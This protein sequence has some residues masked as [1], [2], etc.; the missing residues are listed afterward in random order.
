MQE[1]TGISSC[2]PSS[3]TL[4]MGH[5]VFRALFTRLS[6][7]LPFICYSPFISD[8]IDAIICK[9]STTFFTKFCWPRWYQVTKKGSSKWV[10][11]KDK[12]AEAKSKGCMYKLSDLTL[13]CDRQVTKRIPTECSSVRFAGN[14]LIKYPSNVP[15]PSYESESVL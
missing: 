13:A 10:F 15:R 12:E 9:Y 3:V 1:I 6:G 4:W 8:T 5:V 11:A 2:V 7:D 14:E